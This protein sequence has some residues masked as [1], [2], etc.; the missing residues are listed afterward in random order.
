MKNKKKIFFIVNNPLF[1]FQHLL[2][3]IE[4]LELKVSLIIITPYDKKYI[5]NF[6]KAKIVYLPIKRNPSYWD[7]ISVL[8]LLI[9]KIKY[10]PELS[11]SFTPKAGLINVLTSIFQRKKTYHYFT[12]QR[13]ATY[14]GISKFIFKLIDKYIIF[15]CHK[16]FC[17]SKSQAKFIAKEL[18][19]KNTTLIGKG[20]I[21]GVNIQKFNLEK[22][23]ALKKF[24]QSN[25]NL[26]KNLKNIIE[27]S[28]KG[29]AKIIFYIGRLSKD[30]GIIELI[31]GFKSHHKKYKN[32]FLF[33]IG[34]NELNKNDFKKIYELKNCFHL[35]FTTQINLLLPFAYCLI[36][37]SYREGFGSVIIEAAASKVPI[38]ATNIPGPLDFIDHMQ[39]GYLINPKSSNEIK[40]GLEFF[41]KNETFIMDFATNAFEKCKEFYSEEYVCRLFIREILKDI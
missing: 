5:L 33:L 7:I 10:R 29:K 21:S 22:N 13:W 2:P 28:I 40:K 6:K 15:S 24:N 35:G 36:L 26:S 37:P 17:D 1:I 3:I 34:P 9:I 31:S 14:K 30:K 4:L 8:S 38:I 39:N 41:F 19:F 27:K 16:V 23:K 12:G 18:A 25:L 20:S 11:I 32:S